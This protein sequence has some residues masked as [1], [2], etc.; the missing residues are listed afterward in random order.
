M[1]ELQKVCMS[2]GLLATEYYVPAVT[3]S[4]KQMVLGFQFAVFGPDNLTSGC[5]PFLVSYAGHANHYQV[6]A[7]ADI[8]NQLAQG[9][10][11]ASLMDYWS[12]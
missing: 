12:T 2:R 1:Q 4:L 9:I 5:Q 10:Q 7:A 6:L 3:T 11:S 8:S